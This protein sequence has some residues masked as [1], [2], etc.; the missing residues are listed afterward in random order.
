[1][2]GTIIFH[3]L[4]LLMIVWPWFT[5]VYPIPEPEGLMASFGEVE[6]AGGNNVQQKEQEEQEE[7][8]EVKEDPVEEIEDVETVEDNSSPEVTTEDKP[9]DTISS[10]S[11]ECLEVI[12]ILKSSLPTSGGR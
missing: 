9:K 7:Q 4:L 12:H 2:A 1:M 11:R 5:T 3:M 10:A 8:E 6:I